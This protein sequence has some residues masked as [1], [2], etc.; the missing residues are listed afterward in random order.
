MRDINDLNHEY[1]SDKAFV[2]KNIL[3]SGSTV[4]LGKLRIDEWMVKKIYTNST[5]TEKEITV[6][7]KYNNTNY[8]DLTTAWANKLTLTYE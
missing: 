6:A 1:L 4:Y 8:T 7:N 5:T 2:T 3:S